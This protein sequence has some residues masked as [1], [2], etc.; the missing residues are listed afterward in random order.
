MN[1]LTDNVPFESVLESYLS[2]VMVRTRLAYA[3]S[4]A[5]LHASGKTGKKILVTFLLR[6]HSRT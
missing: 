5:Q 3:I 2:S 1:V 6:G 4:N